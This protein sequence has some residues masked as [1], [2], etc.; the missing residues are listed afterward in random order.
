MIG[1][2][3]RRADG[4]GASTQEGLYWEKIP[5]MAIQDPRI[6]AEDFRLLCILINLKAKA[7]R[8]RRSGPTDGVWHTD[9]QLR[10]RLATGDPA[11]PRVPSRASVQRSLVRLEEARYIDRVTDP[12]GPGSGRQIR[13]PWRPAESKQE[14]RPTG[15]TPPV[16]QVR[17][18]DEGPRAEVGG[19]I[20]PAP[21]DASPERRGVSNR[22]DPGASRERQGR[23]R[24]EAQVRPAGGVVASLVRHH[25]ELD[26]RHKKQQQKPAS[27]SS[28]GAGDTTTPADPEGT[29]P[30]AEA[31]TI[32]EA[33]RSL[34]FT[35]GERVAPA[36]RARSEPAHPDPKAIEKDPNLAR[37][38]LMADEE[39]ADAERILVGLDPASPLW[40][41]HHPRLMRHHAAAKCLVRDGERA[42]G[43]DAN[44][45]R[46]PAEGTHP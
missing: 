5:E 26:Q 2:N 41:L 4:E 22:E 42:A 10:S 6:T 17:Q 30:G 20:D 31:V 39:V 18:V 24:G 11:S 7:D 12:E 9:R 37:R 3:A 23:P 38:Y 27:S 14:G 29:S 35:L 19:G 25:F 16:S 46:R 44:L 28:P 8:N 36:R 40:G 32:P 13:F 34:P 43:P 45:Y 1:N 33:P 15:E 21:E